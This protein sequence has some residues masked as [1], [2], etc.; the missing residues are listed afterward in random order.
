MQGELAWGGSGEMAGVRFTDSTDIQRN[1]LRQWLN[2]QLPEP[3]QD[4]PPVNCG[5]SDLSVGGCYLTTNSP[6]PR[7]TR[8]VLSIQSGDLEVRAVGVVLVAHPEFGMGVEFLQNTP[9]QT[10]RSQRMIAALHADEKH[11][12]VH[13]APD[14]LEPPS[15]DDGLATLQT[16]A[17]GASGTEDPLVD[18]FRQN[19][20]VPAEAFLQQ[21]RE[22][23]AALDPL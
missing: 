6:F 1:T 17:T 9:E 4:D 2:S 18:L 3:E 15:A 16:A 7:G 13:V 20:Q 12:E 19:F 8:V 22:Q 14:G 11:P 23:R 21:M 10:E 5:L